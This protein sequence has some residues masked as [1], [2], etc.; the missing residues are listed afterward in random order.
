[1]LRRLIFAVA[2]T[3]T[4]S[5]AALTAVPTAVAAAPVPL[6]LPLLER[7]DV[8]DRLTITTSHTGNPRADGTFELT[9]AP[10][11]GTHPEA[12]AAC[13]KLAQFA[14]EGKDPFTPIDERSICTMQYGG[15]A[16]A[17]ITGIWRGRNVDATFQRGNGCE[18][19]RWRSLEPVLPTARYQEPAG[20]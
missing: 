8:G 17:R 1:M 2:A 20:S 12:P 7:S 10:A 5:V 6:P 9:C 16:T 3:A 14:K 13:D 11:G 19:G 4:A 15:P 18:I